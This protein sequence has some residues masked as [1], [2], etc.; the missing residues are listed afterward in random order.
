MLSSGILFTWPYHLKVFLFTHSTTPQFIPSTF[1]AIPHLSYTT[2]FLIL[3]DIV[4]PV[5]AFRYIISMVLCL[6]N[7]E[8]RY[9][10]SLTSSKTLFYFNLTVQ[11]TFFTLYIFSK[12]I[13]SYSLLTKTIILLFPAFTLFPPVTY[14]QIHSPSSVNP[15]QSMQTLRHH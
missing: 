10:N 1:S 15:V 13:L 12:S 9:L 7:T 2:S 11:F 4:T 14:S 3:S 6:H 5:A 8:H